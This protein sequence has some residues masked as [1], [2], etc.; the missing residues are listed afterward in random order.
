MMIFWMVVALLIVAALLFVLPPLISRNT[1]GEV[2]ERSS[3]NISIYRDQLA[4]LER[5]RDNDVITPEQYEQGRIELERRLLEDVPEDDASGNNAAGNQTASASAKV[6]QKRG[7]TA[8]VIVGIAIPVFAIGVYQWLGTPQSISSNGRAATS[9]GAAK[10]T[11]PSAM[12]DQI[13]AMVTQLAQRLKDN[14]EDP[15][16][17]AM[18]GR[19]YLV[20]NR[21]DD[22]VKSYEKAMSL[23][24]NDPNILVDYADALAMASGEQSLEGQPMKLIRQALALDP[25]NQKGLW[26]AGTAEFEKGNFQQALEY[27]RRLYKML[28]KD[29]EDALVMQGNIKEAESLISGRSDVASGDQANVASSAANGDL[30][31]HHVTGVVKLDEKLYRQVNDTDTVYVFARA[32]QGPR[33]PLAVMRAQVKDLPLDFSLDDSMAINPAMT[34]SKYP[35]VIVVA[36]ISKSGNATPQSGDMQGLSRVL[37]VGV[38]EANVTINEI[39][40]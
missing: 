14:P 3:L 20:L 33:M 24:N 13:N 26:L 9:A 18:L 23:S 30:Q 36:R 28:P 6:S 15:Q 10:T 39:I 16:G 31:D 12:S 11:N 34:I 8:A 25:N 27:W 22:A 17:W 35:E 29:S 19:S 5:D 38:D 4:E 1:D 40:P 21:P 37:R 32:S 2:V 7:R